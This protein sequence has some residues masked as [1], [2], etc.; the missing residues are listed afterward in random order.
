M[1]KSGGG[2]GK[3]QCSNAVVA[4]RVLKLLS[5]LLDHVTALAPTA[6]ADKAEEREAEGKDDECKRGAELD[7][8]R[9][10]MCSWILFGCKFVSSTLQVVVIP[11]D[12]VRTLLSALTQLEQEA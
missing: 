3:A 12:K 11:E 7:K 6:T 9:R 1:K 5:M 2:R 4:E 8:E 10:E